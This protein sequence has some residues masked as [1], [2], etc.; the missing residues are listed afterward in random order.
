MNS[1]FVSGRRSFDEDDFVRLSITWLDSGKSTLSTVNGDSI[2]GNSDWRTTRLM[3]TAPSG[4]AYARLLLVAGFGTVPASVDAK[5][6]FDDAVFSP[7]E[8]NGGFE[9]E[10]SSA[11]LFW[12][13][14]VSGSGV[15][16]YITTGIADW[17]V[18]SGTHAVSVSNPGSNGDRWFV[19]S[20]D[21][22]SVS[23]GEVY[24]L[25]A[26]IKTEQFDADD[27]V[28][29]SVVWL[30]S[31]KKAISTDT[32]EMIFGNG[33]WRVIQ[34][35]ATAP[36]GALY[37]RPLLVT[38]YGTLTDST[39]ATVTFDQIEF[40]PLTENGA[41]EVENGGM[42]LFWT[43]SVSGAGIAQYITN[44][45]AGADVFDG[46]HAVSISQPGSNGDRWFVP[47]S[48]VPAVTEGET[49]ELSTCVKTEQFDEDDLVRLAIVWLDNSKSTISTVSGESV[50]GNSDWHTI[51]FTA[52]APAGAAYARPL[53]VSGYGTQAASSNMMATFDHTE[54]T[55]MLSNGG[56]E[57]EDGNAPLNWVAVV[58]GSASADYITNGMH[59]VSITQPG[60]A[61]QWTVLNR[62]VPSVTSGES[63]ELQAQVQTEDFDEDDFVRLSVVWLDADRVALGESKG[64]SLFGPSE[65]HTIRFVATAPAGAAY[66]RPVLTA[67]CGSVAAAS[68]ARALFDDVDFGRTATSASTAIEL[69]RIDF[70]TWQVSSLGQIL[71][72]DDEFIELSIDS[73]DFLAVKLTPS[74]QVTLPNDIHR[75][76]GWVVR[77]EGDFD[78]AYLIR[79]ANG[80]NHLVKTFSSAPYYSDVDWA[81]MLRWSRWHQIYSLDMSQPTD[82]ELTAQVIP[83]Y[84]NY[85][86]SLCWEKPLTLVEIQISPVTAP[87][88]NDAQ[89]AADLAAISNGQARLVMASPWILDEDELSVTN[90]WY[91][92]GRRRL[93]W[94]SE[95]LVFPDDLS[96]REGQSSFRLEIQQGY[97]GPVIWRKELT[98]D[99]DLDDFNGLMDQS[100]RL[101]D[102]PKGNYFIHSWAWD[103][104]QELQEERDLRLYGLRGPD[105]TIYPEL[106]PQFALTTGCL[107]EVL[108]AGSTQA[109]LTISRSPSAFAVSPSAQLQLE[110]T[111]WKQNVVLDQTVT[112]E[113]GMTLAVPVGPRDYH[114][115]ATLWDGGTTRDRTRLH[116][117]VKSADS[118]GFSS[119]AQSIPSVRI[120]AEYYRP[121][122]ST[123][124]HEGM[125]VTDETLA[126]YDSWISDEVAARSF[127]HVNNAFPW[128]EIEVLPGAF[129]WEEGDRRNQVAAAA[130]ADLSVL[131]TPLGPTIPTVPDWWNVD[132][133]LNQH[134]RPLGVGIADISA[135]TPP[136]DYW[137]S[138]RDGMLNWVSEAVQHFRNNPAVSEYRF[139]LEPFGDAPAAAKEH[140][141]CD[142]SD[143]FRQA[144]ADWL[145]SQGKTPMDLPQPLAVPGYTMDTF[146]PDLSDAWV[147][148]M[149]F[150][151]HTLVQRITDIAQTV[152][153]LDTERPL[154]FYRGPRN[155]AVEAAIPVLQ[156]VGGC[157][158]DEGAPNFFANALASLCVQNGV[159]FT[160][161]NHNFKPNS[162]EIIDAD[163]FYGSIYNQGWNFNYRWH[164]RFDNKPYI[165]DALDFLSASTPILEDYVAAQAD[166]P[167]VLVFGSR[168]DA[169]VNDG[170]FS[171]YNRITGIELFTSLFSYYQIPVHFADEY[172]DWVDLTDFDVVFVCGEAMRQSAIDRIETFAQ[173]GGKV[174]LVDGAGTYSVEQPTERD[175]LSDALTGLSNVRTMQRP[176]SA[177][178]A[179]GASPGAPASPDPQDIAD[180]LT[181]SGFERSVWTEISGVLDQ[182]FECLY[183][184]IDTQS[185]YVGVF[186]R[187]V[188]YYTSI[189]WIDQNLA[190]WGEAETTVVVPNLSAGSY[191]V[192]KIHRDSKSVAH[193]LQNGV[194]QFDTDLAVTG[195]LQIFKVT[196]L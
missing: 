101:P 88:L 48:D 133:Q 184:Q 173:N 140:R 162:R 23:E 89:S 17:D 12:A 21:V 131:C 112:F 134:G 138:Y 119:P 144:F 8:F 50:L 141:Y 142:Y 47:S 42:P 5:A 168:I 11:P 118:S 163:I 30:D 14:S 164:E 110:V 72:Q 9:A 114:A 121:W 93:G 175:L 6:S 99:V 85:V 186:R 182:R 196:K 192:E 15:A 172:T 143:A 28:R 7:V 176:T 4:A 56:F 24:N 124:P 37:A 22:P 62:A 125:D 174:V 129:R 191:T 106:E 169:F 96:E 26:G 61:D 82:A 45:T 155:A 117:A 148:M 107:N 83:E 63:Y 46:T 181:W 80:L 58:S 91:Q 73:P 156:Q 108:P 49:Y 40:E 92:H 87:R 130:G 185:F 167:S 44:G 157:F 104:D 126:Y 123:R 20:A 180:I 135:R 86:D 187:F 59:A 77:A 19:P 36:V 128:S 55:R 25:R 67:G 52:T 109:A 153:A 39:N 102:L 65:W 98:K 113:S 54:F 145:S 10:S 170:R 137:F 69:E 53:L 60:A 31:S 78:I 3:A 193:T 139:L 41:F 149:D 75:L 171:N 154:S 150:K 132:L 188:D 81:E 57:T 105:D 43:A 159:R 51:R 136:C 76:G 177:P 122:Y 38:G 68:M 18:C 161:E 27:F 94:N 71:Q 158:H 146:G 32:G 166:E 16:D 95:N 70:S 13:S 178:P 160:Y 35:S 34:L 100:I 97:Q 74:T 115:V 116:F 84:Q 2:L 151:T 189:E 33:D 111:D 194:L 29:L 64:S 147:S 195:E 152:R 90:S 183:R 66:A 1:V 165:G 179:P 103:G 120:D 79:D 127:T 190:L